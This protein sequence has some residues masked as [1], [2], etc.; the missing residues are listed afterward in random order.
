MAGS[1]FTLSDDLITIWRHYVHTLLTPSQGEEDPSSKALVADDQSLRMI[2]LACPMTYLMEYRVYD[3]RS[4]E[5]IVDPHDSLT[6]ATAYE[7]VRTQRWLT[8]I[9][10]DDDPVT[11]QRFR[12]GLCAIK[13]IATESR[14]A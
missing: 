6:S 2:T 5:K 9:V 7:T 13:T 4:L 12:V 8:P 3:V 14:P 10:L 1:K 11:H